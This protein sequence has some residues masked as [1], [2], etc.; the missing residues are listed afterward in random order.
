MDVAIW[1]R[2]LSESAMENA[3]LVVEAEAVA[4]AVVVVE[5]VSIITDNDVDVEEPLI[6]EVVL[7]SVHEVTS[8]ALRDSCSEV[9][10]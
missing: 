3:P 5:D 9:W 2:G 7:L 6:I 10:D 8:N 4:M 1:L